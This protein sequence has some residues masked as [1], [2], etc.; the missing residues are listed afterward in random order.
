MGDFL[1]MAKGKGGKGGK[2]AKNAVADAVMDEVSDTIHDQ[3]KILKEEMVQVIDKKL[4]D[5][6]KVQLQEIND[7]QATINKLKQGNNQFAETADAKLSELSS[8]VSQ[9]NMLADELHN[10]RNRTS[11]L[12]IECQEIKGKFDETS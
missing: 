5:K 3:K 10:L 4:D 7:L 8:S 9:M 12:K 6:I 2:K 1:E 11:S